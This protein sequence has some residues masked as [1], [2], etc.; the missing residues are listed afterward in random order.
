MYCTK[1]FFDFNEH[2]SHLSQRL[3]IED[4]VWLVRTLKA[5]RMMIHLPIKWAAEAEAVPKTHLDNVTPVGHRFPRLPQVLSPSPQPGCLCNPAISVI[6]SFA[7]MCFR[8]QQCLTSPVNWNRI[9]HWVQRN[10]KENNPDE[11][12]WRLINLNPISYTEEANR[13]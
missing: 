10:E 8:C 6:H 9:T 12:G 4:D 7:Y 5:E 2:L 13:R 1:S 3:C 11:E